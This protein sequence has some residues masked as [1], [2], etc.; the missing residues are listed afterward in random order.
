MNGWNSSWKRTAK[1]ELFIVFTHCVFWQAKATSAVQFKYKE[2][3][4]HLGSVC[5][6]AFNEMRFFPFCVIHQNRKCKFQIYFFLKKKSLN[7]IQQISQ[8]IVFYPT[9]SLPLFPSFA[10]APCAV[11]IYPIMFCWLFSLSVVSFQQQQHTQM[12]LP[13]TLQT[14]VS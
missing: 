1:D 6:D 13:G 2:E 7:D 14:A 3:M 4:N 8:L 12:Y 10:E 9:H 11:I 5:I